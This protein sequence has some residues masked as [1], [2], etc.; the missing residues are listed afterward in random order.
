MTKGEEPLLAVTCEFLC[1]HIDMNTRRTSPFA[2]QLA[3]K[4][5]RLIAEHSPLRWGAAGD[6]TLG[7]DTEF[8]GILASADFAPLSAAILDHLRHE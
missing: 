4:I 7:I 1:A 2:P 8:K 3:E 5:N 6:I